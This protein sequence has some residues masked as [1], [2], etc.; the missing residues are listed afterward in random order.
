MKLLIIG[1]GF[2]GGITGAKYKYLEP[3]HDIELLSLPEPTNGEE[4][5]WAAGVETL[6]QQLTASPPDVMIACS[7]GGKYAG[8][9]IV[10]GLW[11][12]PTFLIS[13]LSTAECCVSGVPVLVCHGTLDKT[14][15]IER[16]RGDVAASSTAQLEEI[17]DNHSL[18]KLVDEDL[19]NSLLS[20]C[21]QMQFQEP[22]LV[23]ARAPVARAPAMGALFAEMRAKKKH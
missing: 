8:K 21:H 18:H 16:V 13:A 4:E 17:E 10:Q 6:A 5:I 1:P 19:F 20:R 11:K 7:R 15:A 3:S 14:N 22:K 2:G 9:V 12:G 23:Q